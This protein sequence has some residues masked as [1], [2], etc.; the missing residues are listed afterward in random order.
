MVQPLRARE[1]KSLAKRILSGGRVEFSGHARREM[2]KDG[3]LDQ[4]AFFA[5]QAGTWREAEWENGGWR[6][7]VHAVDYV[8]VV[9][10]IEELELLVVTGWRKKG[11]KR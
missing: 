1:A 2:Q 5:L 9:E 11:R 10:F 8:I 3:L 4:D 7:Q 6:H